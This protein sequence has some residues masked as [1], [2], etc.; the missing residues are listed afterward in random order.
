[1]ED[2]ALQDWIKEKAAGAHAP[3]QDQ[4]AADPAAMLLNW[5]FD[6][7]ETYLEKL[8]MLSPEKK[9]GMVNFFDR[10]AKSS[11][12]E[13]RRIYAEYAEKAEDFYQWEGAREPGMREW[14]F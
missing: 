13:L 6:L 10:I 8:K 5:G 11:P 9:Q 1:M 7:H 14:L 3:I 12:E 2:K 4:V